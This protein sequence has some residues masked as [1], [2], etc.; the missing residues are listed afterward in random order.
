MVAAFLC[1]AVSAFGQIVGTAAKTPC[2]NG[3]YGCSGGNPYSVT[4]IENG[5]VV[6][7]AVVGT[8]TSPQYEVVNDTGNPQTTLTFTLNLT[9]G[10]SFAGN[11]TLQCQPNG[12]V[13]T[14]CTLTANGTNYGKSIET[15]MYNGGAGFSFPVT[16]QFTGLNI[17]AG[18]DFDITFA[19]FANGD[20]G[21]QTGGSVPEGSGIAMLGAS[22]LVLLGTLVMKKRL[23]G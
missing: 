9:A 3:P 4:G 7:Q 17:C 21:I 23:V 1:F 8:Q 11:Q 5:S 14:G 10:G 2:G 12:S 22:G 15:P 18:C 16:I 6:L 13:G 19:S 20:H